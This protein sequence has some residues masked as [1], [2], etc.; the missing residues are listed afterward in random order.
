MAANIVDDTDI[1]VAVQGFERLSETVDALIIA[2]RVVTNPQ[3]NK[4]IQEAVAH[5]GK[6]L[7]FLSQLI[8]TDRPRILFVDTYGDLENLYEHC[9]VTYLGCGFDTRKRGFDPMESLSAGVPVILGPIYDF[10]RIALDSLKNTEGVHILEQKEGA[11]ED[12]V[13]LAK[14]LSEQKPAV[15]ELQGVLENRALDPLRVVDELLGDLVARGNS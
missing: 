10:N 3:R 6:E 1:Q 4:K 7:S 9:C 2:P 8:P 14:G 13:R 11:V 5:I 15:H 12:F